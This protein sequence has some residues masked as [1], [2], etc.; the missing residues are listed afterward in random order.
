M[1]DEFASSQLRAAEEEMQLEKVLDEENYKMS[2]MLL[3]SD[4]LD[5]FEEIIGVYHQIISEITEKELD[6]QTQ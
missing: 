6:E 1:R 4:E 2:L 3:R 5:S